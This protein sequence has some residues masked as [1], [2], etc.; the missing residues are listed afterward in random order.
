[1]SRHGV[2]PQSIK[3]PADFAKVPCID[4]ANYLHK[5]PLDMLVWDGDLSKVTM[6][7]RSSGSSGQ[8][9]YWPRGKNQEAEVDFIYDNVYRTF[10]DAHKKK[11]LVIG[12]FALG[13]WVGGTFNLSATLKF[14]ENNPVTL[15]TPGAN[16]HE[17][18]ELAVKLGPFFDQIII[19]AY[20]PFV[21]E[22][23]DTGV[24]EGV[25]WKKLN[26]KFFYA[27]ETFSEPFREHLLSLVGSNDALTGSVN[28]IGTADAAILGHETPLSIAIRRAATNDSNLW[29][30]LFPAHRTPTL[31]QYYPEFKYFEPL[32]GGELAFTTDGGIPLVR[33]NIHDH[34]K[35]WTQ[36]Q[37]FT[38]LDAH[39]ISKAQ[40]RSEVGAKNMWIL[41]FLCIYGKSDQ[42]VPFYGAKVFPENIKSLLEQ[43]AWANVFTGKFLMSTAYDDNMNPHIHL[44][45]EL[46]HNAT[47]GGGLE[48]RFAAILFDHLVAVNSEF[49]IISKAVGEAK[50]IPQVKLHRFGDEQF[51]ADIKL[52]WVSSNPR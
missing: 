37:M 8:P 33:Y 16:K 23:I 44:G 42:T 50:S 35:I 41:P 1:L 26:V 34:G 29:K 2:Q 25:D 17:I 20:P 47:P 36:E 9:Y 43:K 49:A 22:V 13:T 19:G 27:A 40:L 21:K 48:S 15:V 10:F 51:K 52:R 46:A 5:Y 7:S 30:E 32:E 4:K 3:T 6:I 31:G 24:A 11:T 14:A 12:G 39:G 18:I 38:L 45:M 28:I